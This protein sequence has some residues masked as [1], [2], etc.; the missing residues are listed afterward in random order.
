MADNYNATPGSGL[1][2]AGDDIGGVI[3]PRI[4]IQVGADGVASDVSAASPLPAVIG[5]TIVVSSE[6]TR[7]ADT[8]AYGISD[9]VNNS[10]SA[11][12]LLTIAGVA[13]INGYG[14]IICGIRISTNLKS[15]VPAFR[16][17]L[18][19]VSN[20]T[21]SAD[22][23]AWK[24]LYADAGKRVGYY[25]MPAMNTAVDAANSDT[26]R[27]V[28]FNVRLP[29]MCAAS[30]RS[31]YIALETLTAFTPASGQKFTVTLHVAQD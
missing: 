19:N 14:G 31:L 17:H 24:E 3:S 26:S 5:N 23:A 15:I 8:T 25:D 2:F 20:P 21:L 7:P 6:F 28:D 29:F 22:N 11:P 18:F 16:V 12:T 9:A 30:D 27:S 4:K 1:T 10:T 13:R